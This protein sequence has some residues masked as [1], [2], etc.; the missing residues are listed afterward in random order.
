M[1]GCPLEKFLQTFSEVLFLFPEAQRLDKAAFLLAHY[2]K[3]SEDFKPSSFLDY[4]MEKGD[5]D[6]ELHRLLTFLAPYGQGETEAEGKLPAI[7]WWY[8]SVS[9]IITLEDMQEV[10]QEVRKILKANE[11]VITF[12]AF[13]DLLSIAYDRWN[14]EHKKSI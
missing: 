8:A 12:H 13:H 3:E 14:A 2:S 10:E 5:I 7:M 6:K 1:I 9:P 4:V 11:N